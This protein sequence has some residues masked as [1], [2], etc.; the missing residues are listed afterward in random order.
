MK[1]TISIV[2]LRLLLT[3]IVLLSPQMMCGSLIEKSLRLMRR[4][5]VFMRVELLMIRGVSAVIRSNNFSELVMRWLSYLM[6]SP[7]L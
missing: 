4:V 2:Q 5:S 6:I 1:R 3:I 7:R